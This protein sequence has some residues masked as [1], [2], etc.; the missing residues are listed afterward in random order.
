MRLSARAFDSSR[1]KY[2]PS[3]EEAKHSSMQEGN[4]DFMSSGPC[5]ANI[6]AYQAIC[7]ASSVMPYLALSSLKYSCIWVLISTRLLGTRYSGSIHQ[8]KKCSLKSRLVRSS[9]A[10]AIE[11]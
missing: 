6:F 4:S 2:D 5:S 1:L 7:S 8:G 3:S 11:S 10:L 9:P